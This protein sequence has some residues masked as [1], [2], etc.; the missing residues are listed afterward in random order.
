MG[1]WSSVPRGLTRVA[2]IDRRVAVP[3]QEPHRS[4]GGGTIR[5]FSRVAARDGRE[6]QDNVSRNR[7]IKDRLSK[8][9][10]AVRGITLVGRSDGMSR[11]YRVQFAL[12]LQIIFQ[13]QCETSEKRSHERIHDRGEGSNH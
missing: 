5:N 7:V 4:R 13:D 2:S 1:E 3:Q 10:D 9:V 6:K 8:R 12:R 11:A